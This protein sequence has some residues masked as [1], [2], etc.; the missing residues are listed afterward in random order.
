MRRG[1][2]ER[3]YIEEQVFGQLTSLEAGDKTW[4]NDRDAVEKKLNG[5]LDELEGLLDDLAE[6]LGSLRRGCMR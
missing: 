3:E 2:K 5:Y 4:E 1:E 6:F